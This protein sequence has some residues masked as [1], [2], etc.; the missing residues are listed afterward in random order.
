MANKKKETIVRVQFP[1]DAT[2]GD[3]FDGIRS[4]QDEW[5]KNNPDEA[6]A[7][8]PEVYSETGER[9]KKDTKKKRKPKKSGE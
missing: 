4:L 9:V 7:L 1:K 6:H 3:I 8:Y 5:A 2:A